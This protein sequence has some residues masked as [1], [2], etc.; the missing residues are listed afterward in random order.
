MELG[1]RTSRRAFLGGLCAV[2]LAAALVRLGAPR[3]ARA[4]ELAEPG[5][6]ET[7]ALAAAQQEYDAAQEQLQ[8]VGAQLES[9]Q[10]EISRI[11]AQLAQL[12]ID[13]DDTRD[14]IA[15]TTSDLE[16]AQA[17]L[18]A[19]IQITYKS[20][21][22]SILDVLLSSRDFNDFVT[23][24]YYVGAV[25]D[26]QVETINEIRDLKAQ[27]E[28]QEETLSDQE[29][30]QSELLAQLQEQETAL[31]QQRD[32][33]DQIVNSL[34]TEV[35]ALFEAQQA[36]LQAAAE[37]RARASAAATGGEALGVYAP[38]TSQ[39]S[40]VENA[41]ACLG[42]PY[43]W[44]GD[45]DNFAEVGGFDCSGFVQH[46]YALEGYS[47]GRTTWDQ[48]ADIQ[49]R[50]NWK[51]TLD[52]L[53]PGDLVFPSDAHVGVYIGE[54]QMIDAPYPGMFIQIDTVE[55]YIGGGLPV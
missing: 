23:R 10:V 11:Q 25:Q 55:E 28:D 46:C 31:S 39:G 16:A 19:F 20:G 50:G 7:A 34:S 8:E 37:A 21:A 48:I 24:S 40:V 33:A 9:T 54:G 52:E 26:S 49:N 45:D 36:Q 17:A 12:E 5:E 44:G 47:I 41:Y 35:Q 38:A 27:L 2:P 51:T 29:T 53:N 18:A 42:I 43:V 1:S 22:T 15:Q 14:G 3:A 30:E 13:I 32:E 6:A 4:T